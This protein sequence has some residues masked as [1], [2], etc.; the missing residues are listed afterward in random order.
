MHGGNLV[1]ESAEGEG[2]TVTIYMPRDARP[3]IKK[4]AKTDG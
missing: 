1:I 4:G 3:H 2:T